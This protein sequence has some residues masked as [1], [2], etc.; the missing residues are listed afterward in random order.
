M[1]QPRGGLPGVE[2]NVLFLVRVP[3]YGITDSGRG[4][5]LRLDADARQSGLKASFSQDCT[6]SQERREEMPMPSCALMWTICSTV[7]FQK[8]N[9]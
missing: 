5:W 1:K 7:F 6:T 2:P 4:F 3:V 8:V 9:R